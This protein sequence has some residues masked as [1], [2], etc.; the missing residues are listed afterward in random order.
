MHYGTS[1]RKNILETARAVGNFTTLLAVIEHAGL[2]HTLTDGGPFTMFAP[3]DEAFAELPE[4]TVE[5]LFAEP[6]TL[7][8]IVAYH[9]VPGR[10]A[11]TEVAYLRRAP[12]LQGEMLRLSLD[13]HLHV[14]GARLVDADIEASNGLIHVID[15]VLLPA[16][17]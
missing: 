6:D 10:L 3:H 9:L 8:S 12:T 15:R 2:A 17:I 5:S 4:G 1:T 7:T 16:Q 13:G 11:L 14:D